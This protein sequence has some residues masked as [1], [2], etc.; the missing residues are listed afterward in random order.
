M[1]MAIK[2]FIILYFKDND[3]TFNIIC[4]PTSLDVHTLIWG[5]NEAWGATQDS[6][7]LLASTCPG[8]TLPTHGGL[9]SSQ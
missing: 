8:L 6:L 4:Y 3:V 9:C 7:H 2:F 1:M 5:P